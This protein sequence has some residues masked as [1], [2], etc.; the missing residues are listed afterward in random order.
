MIRFDTHSRI[1]LKPTAEDDHQEYS[2]EA[3]HE[4][5]SLDMPMKASIQLSVLCKKT[6]NSLLDLHYNNRFCDFLQILQEHRT[7]R[8]TRKARQ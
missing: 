1:S 7:L 8:V 4:A 2:C 3:R 6:S 5:L